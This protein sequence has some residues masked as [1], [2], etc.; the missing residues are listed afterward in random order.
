MLA[1]MLTFTASFNSCN[2]EEET[3]APATFAGATISADNSTITVSFDK[4]VYKNADGTGNLDGANFTV[5]MSGGSATPGT[6]NVQHTAGQTAAIISFDYTGAA[7]GSEVITI[8]PVSIYNADGQAMATTAQVTV[9]LNNLGIVGQWQS[10][11]AN[12]APLLSTYFS[13]DSIWADFKADQTYDVKSYDPDGVMTQYLGTYTQT[14]SSTG[15]IWTIVLEQ[16]APSTVTSEGIFE[17]DMDA[18]GYD[19]RYEV[20]QTEPNLG[21]SPAT[22]EGGFGSTNNGQLGES[23]VQKFIKID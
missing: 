2:E 7:D 3:D 19:L 6:F 5:T 18:V 15:N 1:I 21:N 10:S 11:G 22:P 4:S 16:S 8:S 13:V 20:A 12:V 14:K 23:N 17:I 9:T